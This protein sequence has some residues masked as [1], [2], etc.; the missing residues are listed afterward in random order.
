MTRPP[1]TGTAAGGWYS[2]RAAVQ[3]LLPEGA[4]GRAL[5]P[6]FAVG[7]C[8]SADPALLS[9]CA[10]CTQRRMSSSWRPNLPEDRPE[11]TPS[12]KA[13]QLLSMEAVVRSFTP[14][15]G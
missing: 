2:R 13:R 9:A 14:D 15:S 3:F 5:Q 8:D 4:P 7:V 10:D 1:S 11:M 12:W 6:L